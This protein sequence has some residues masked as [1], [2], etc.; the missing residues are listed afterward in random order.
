MN[1]QSFEGIVNDLARQQIVEAQAREEALL[2]STECETCAQ[3]L[4][5]ELRLTFALKSLATDT[6]SFV[7]PLRIE[8]HLRQ[9]LR[10]QTFSR[11]Q[12]RIARRLDYWIVAAAAVLL[13]AFGIAAI[14]LRLAQPVEQK[15][16][17]LEAGAKPKAEQKKP[18]SVIEMPGFTST[19][20]KDNGSGSKHTHLSRR[21]GPS[22]RNRLPRATVAKAA[23][24]SPANHTAT[25]ITTKFMPLGYFTPLNLEEGGQLVRVEVSR[26]AM[27]S[28]GL[29]V[30]MDRYGER[31]KADV[32]VGSDGQAR[33]IRFVQ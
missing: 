5:D 1:C 4:K 13:I 24:T 9:A 25:E 19:T 11:P 10:N 31:V 20:A 7:M 2:H 17:S 12:K 16:S 6:K 8:E 29:P 28:L 27:M 15:P 22:H 33:A 3:R 18:A 32:L 26:S 21:F 23:T 14:G 30:N